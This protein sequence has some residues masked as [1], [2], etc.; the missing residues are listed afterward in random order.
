MG[1]Y[2]EPITIAVLISFTACTCASMEYH[3]EMQPP[4]YQMVLHFTHTYTHTHTHIVVR[5]REREREKERES[6]RT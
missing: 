6:L 3:T 5:A 4:L 2:R 1:H